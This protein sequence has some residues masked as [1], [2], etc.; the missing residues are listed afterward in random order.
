MID[1][2][3][4]KES[5]IALEN[6][7][8]SFNSNYKQKDLK[9]FDKDIEELSGVLKSLKEVESLTKEKITYT[10]EAREREREYHK[11]VYGERYNE[12]HP[13]ERLNEEDLSE[14]ELFEWLFGD[15]DDP[16]EEKKEAPK[17]PLLLK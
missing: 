4:C 11:K 1:Y 15:L 10:K 6:L 9:M 13:K 2:Y 17:E 8:N 14:E 16:K 7:E 12:R 5:D 3:R